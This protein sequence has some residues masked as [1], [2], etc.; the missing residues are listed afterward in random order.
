MKVTGNEKLRRILTA[1]NEIE[2]MHLEKFCKE[3]VDELK[4]L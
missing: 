3:L 2:K 1:A 4:C